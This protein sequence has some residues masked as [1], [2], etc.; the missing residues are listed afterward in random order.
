MTGRLTQIEE[1]A[2]KMPLGP[3][4]RD[5]YCGVPCR[6]VLALVEIAKAAQALADEAFKHRS[7]VWCGDY[8]NAVTQTRAALARL[9]N[10]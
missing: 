9:D 6:D 2:R 10:Q 4:T 8:E 3:F 1:R 5:T 7:D